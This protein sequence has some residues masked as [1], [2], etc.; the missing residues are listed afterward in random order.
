M[1][2]EAVA[3]RIAPVLEAFP[4]AKRA[5]LFGSQ[6][7]GDASAVSDVDLRLEIDRSQKC[8][9]FDIAELHAALEGVLE[10]PVDLITAERLAPRFSDSIGRDGVLVYERAVV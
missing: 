6:A 3:D 2:V 9:L 1:L 10:K 7:R 8:S 5:M 4:A